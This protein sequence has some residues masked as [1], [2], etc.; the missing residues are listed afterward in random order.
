MLKVLTIS[1]C[2]VLILAG[3]TLALAQ[4]PMAP[5]YPPRQEMRSNLV[6][7]QSEQRPTRKLGPGVSG[8]IPNATIRRDLNTGQVM[9]V[10]GSVVMPQAKTE[11]EAA[12]QFLNTHKTTLGLVQAQAA[13]LRLVHERKSPIGT[14]VTFAHYFGGLQV[15]NSEVVVEVNKDT[16]TKAF[17]VTFVNQN[18]IPIARRAQLV[19]PRDSQSAIEAALAALKDKGTTSSTPKAESGVLVRNGIP[20]TAWRVTFDTLGAAWEVF[21]N[22]STRNV[23]SVRNIARYAL[24]PD[25]AAAFG[26]ERKTCTGTAMIYWP[27]PVQSSGDTG[28]G[29]DDNADSPA[30]TEYRS[31]VTLHELDCSGYL[32]G[33][34]AST[35]P[36][37][38]YRLAREPSINFNYTRSDKRFD[39]V[40]AYHWVT[41]A[42]LYLRSLGFVDTMSINNRQIGLHVDYVDPKEG[43]LS[44]SYY[45]SATKQFYYGTLP[46]GAQDG[47]TI[48]HEFGHAIQDDQVSGWGDG[49]ESGA[50][51]EGFGDYWAASFFAGVGA[52]GHDWD[53][54]VAEFRGIPVHPPSMGLPGY[55]RRV[56]GTKHYPDDLKQEVHE[57]GEIWSACLWQIHNIIGRERADTVIVGS[58]YRL[59]PRSSFADGANAILYANK[60]LYEDRDRNAIRKVFVDRGIL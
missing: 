22:A 13:D 35:A 51:G 2:F 3:L 5:D 27:N 29:N 25:R 32:I 34:Y 7:Q 38:G 42:E 15:F 16:K 20:L 8:V 57:D 54:F 18:I 36:T 26:P 40:M 10:E 12:T 28:L 30:L 1:I 11:S 47:D 49:D 50:M 60:V 52:K 48:L 9:E 41:E 4:R 55:L 59:S 39:M 17:A 56:D 23:L 37:D 53:A 46:H 44:Y 19:S 24:T 45:S 14:Y 33:S 58:H 21:V 6:S 43:E 31:K